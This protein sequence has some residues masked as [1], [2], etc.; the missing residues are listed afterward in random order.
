MLKYL[1]VLVLLAHGIGHVMGFLAAWT[2]LPM[3]FTARPWLL[4]GDVTVQSAIGR[5]FGLL[6]LVAMVGTVG[7]ALGLLSG[8]GWWTPM[9]IAASVIS[10]VAILPWWN[11]VTPGS[12]LWATLV[13]LAII[14]ALAG[15]WR[16]RIL[17]ALR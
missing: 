2:S 4:S 5:A 16:D 11:T 12:R 3:G 7:A 13:D 1:V 14:G 8:Q 15:P 6:W 9:A 10:L 17:E